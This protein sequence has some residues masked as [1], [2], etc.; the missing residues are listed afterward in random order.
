MWLYSC[1]RNIITLVYKVLINC[2]DVFLFDIKMYIHGTIFSLNNRM[3]IYMVWTWE[4]QALIQLLKY[5]WFYN[6]YILIVKSFIHTK[7][8]KLHIISER[9][10]YLQDKIHVHDWFI[11]WN[12]GD[13]EHGNL[14]FKFLYSWFN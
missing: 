1:S 2:W 7:I 13:E 12:Y 4:I 5:I 10:A 3:C 6:A 8:Y 9:W 11:L 14:W